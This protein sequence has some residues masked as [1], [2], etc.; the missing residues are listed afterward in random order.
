MQVWFLIQL[1]GFLVRSW[2]QHI[3]NWCHQPLLRLSH[4]KVCIIT[5]SVVLLNT[6]FFVRCG[7][8]IWTVFGENG[9]SEYQSSGTIFR[10]QEKPKLL[11]SPCDMGNDRFQESAKGGR[12][13][14]SEGQIPGILFSPV[15]W[16]SSFNKN[17]TKILCSDIMS[18]RDFS[19]AESHWEMAE[20]R[21]RDGLMA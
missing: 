15:Y 7:A 17:K 4:Y 14:F 19:G 12:S 8:E 3:S 18:M 9:M 13:C 11:F 10:F 5:S 6:T 20:R 16:Y 1:Q 2:A 21:L